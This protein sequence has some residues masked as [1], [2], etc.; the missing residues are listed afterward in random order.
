MKKARRP[1]GARAGVTRQEAAAQT[2]ERIVAA[3][4]TLFH[5]RGFDA[6]TTDEIAAAAGVAKGTL[7][8]HAPTKERLLVL[9]YQEDLARVSARALSGLPAELPVPVALARVFGRFFH[10][11]EKEPDLARRFVQEVQFLPPNA[12]PGLE[13]VRTAF[14]GRLV[15]LLAE[16]QA[17]GEIAPDVDLGLA[18][19]DSFVIYYGILT[20]WLS[21][22]V[23]DAAARDRFLEDSLSLLWRGLDAPARASTRRSE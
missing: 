10:L 15:R 20:G 22:V 8:L 19:L 12:A 18:A 17:R 11:Y 16:R 1:E 2:H 6:V 13:E 23:P 5:E 3:A 21:G 4:R 14:V 9:A 7:F